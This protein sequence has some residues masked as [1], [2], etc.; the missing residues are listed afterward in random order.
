MGDLR[1]KNRQSQAD[2]EITVHPDF[3]QNEM[4]VAKMG[5]YIASLPGPHDGFSFKK[6]GGY[7]LDYEYLD[8]GNGREKHVAYVSYTA[9]KDSHKRSACI[10]INL[11]QGHEE[12][13]AFVNKMLPFLRKFL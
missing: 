7:S 1:P 8:F 12:L 13:K 9:P 3:R 2:D 4:L 5:H 11:Y 6:T 10:P